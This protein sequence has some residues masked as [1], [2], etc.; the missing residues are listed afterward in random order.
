[1]TAV[2]DLINLLK[3]NTDPRRIDDIRR[4]WPELLDKLQ[5]LIPESQGTH[6]VTIVPPTPQGYQPTADELQLTSTTKMTGGISHF[7]TPGDASTRGRNMGVSGEPA[8]R[9]KD[10]Y[11]CA[12]RWGYVAWHPTTF[13]PN[14]NI[15]GMSD[16]EKFRL[17]KYLAGRKIKVTVLSTGRSCVLRCADAGP[18]IGKRIVDV[19]PSV[20]HNILGAVTDDQVRV[21]WVSPDT[22]LG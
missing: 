15:P 5:A 12:M 9:P 21:E 16:T 8:D 13:K 11:Y 10:I 17:K 22:K 2:D 4:V 19:S 20:L 6:V 1:M 18:S 3:Q 14:G 7:A